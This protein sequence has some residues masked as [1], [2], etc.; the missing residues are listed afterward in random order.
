MKTASLFIC[1]GI[2]ATV[3]LFVSQA[4]TGANEQSPVTQWEYKILESADDTGGTYRTLNE[5]GEEGWELV[6]HDSFGTMHFRCIF[7]R[8]KNCSA[9]FFVKPIV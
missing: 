2:L 1:A 8:P 4:T 3:A 5:F 7:K 9:L 6:S